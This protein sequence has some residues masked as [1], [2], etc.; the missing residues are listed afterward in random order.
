M[1]FCP[2]CGKKVQQDENYCASCGESL[3]HD[4][5]DRAPKRKIAKRLIFIPILVTS[6]CCCFLLA[7]FAFYQYNEGKAKTLFSQAEEMALIGDY[8]Q[9]SQLLEESIQVKDNFPAAKTALQ[10]F[11]KV[12]IIQDNFKQVE[13]FNQ[14]NKYDQSLTLLKQTENVMRNYTGSLVDQLTTKTNDLRTDTM[15]QQIAYHLSNDPDMED[16]KAIIWKVD[17]MEHDRAKQLAE[18]A[19]QNLSSITYQKATLLLKEK[20]FNQAIS[21]IDDTLTYVDSS[22]QLESLKTTINKEKTV[23]ETA[24]QE[25]LE[26]AMSLVE[27]EKELNQ[28]NALKEIDSTIDIQGEKVMIKGE[29]KSVATIPIHSIKV[30]YSL[31]SED[32][33]KILS[34]EVFLIPDTLYPQEIGQF[35]FSHFDIEKQY[36]K[37]KL[38]LKIEEITWYLN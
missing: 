27:E 4:L 28:N 17:G 8:E 14:D 19:R 38:S 6:L 21:L 2:Y 11:N 24:Q 23:F 30:A 5:L 18:T 25:R 7:L 36:L 32:E 3:P 37:D 9:A 29:L 16:L 22:K 15:T 10:F 1:A 33:K 12:S 31:Y 20:Q 34:N 26:Q 35:E 13:Q